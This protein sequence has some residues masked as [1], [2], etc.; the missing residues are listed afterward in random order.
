MLRNA[1]TMKFSCCGAALLD[2]V[3]AAKARAHTDALVEPSWKRLAD[4]L[5]NVSLSFEVADKPFGTASTWLKANRQ[6]AG[7]SWV[8]GAGLAS[9]TLGGMLGRAR[10]LR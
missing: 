10:R 7:E 1:K 5:G 6:L 4:A 9:A 8:A 3:K 2:L